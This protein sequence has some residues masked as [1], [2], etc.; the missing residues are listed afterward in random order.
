MFNGV[1]CIVMIVIYYWLFIDLMKNIGLVP[2]IDQILKI[3]KKNMKLKFYLI[4]FSV[5]FVVLNKF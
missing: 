1:I 5:E 3:I 4:I 2:I